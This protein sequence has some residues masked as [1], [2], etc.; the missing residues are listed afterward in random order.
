MVSRHY[1]ASKQAT[2]YGR[3]QLI[4]SLLERMLGKKNMVIILNWNSGT[5]VVDCVH[6]F[7]VTL[8]VNQA[9]HMHDL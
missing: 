4:A 2:G 5:L 3:A 6:I 9:L 8:L 1:K 7:S